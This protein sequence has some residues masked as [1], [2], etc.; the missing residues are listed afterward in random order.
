MSGRKPALL[1]T[2][3]TLLLIKGQCVLTLSSLQ[4]LT[5]LSIYELDVFIDGYS[6]EFTNDSMPPIGFFDQRSAVSHKLSQVYKQ[7][8]L[9]GGRFYRKNKQLRYNGFGFPKVT[10][11]DHM[12]QTLLELK[13]PIASLQSL[14]FTCAPKL[15]SHFLKQTQGRSALWISPFLDAGLRLVFYHQNELKFIRYIPYTLNDPAVDND[16]AYTLA[17]VQNEYTCNLKELKILITSLDEKETQPLMHLSSPTAIFKWGNTELQDLQK[18]PRT[19]SSDL[20]EPWLISYGQKNKPKIG[21]VIQS[22]LKPIVKRTLWLKS[23][24]FLLQS[25]CLIVCLLAATKIYQFKSINHQL[26]LA[27]KAMLIEKEKVDKL[28][29]HL[30]LPPDLNNHKFYSFLSQKKQLQNSQD[31]VVFLSSL[32]EFLKPHLLVQELLWRGTP[33]SELKLSLR[34]LRPQ[35]KDKESILTQFK[36]QLTEFIKHK[37]GT[38]LT[39]TQQAMHTLELSWL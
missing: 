37:G 3:K 34:V 20:I 35:I 8:Q 32:A 21:I 10:K 36:S 26:D 13:L 5:K 9:F 16:L 1:I 15:L 23:S 22:P 25:I 12:L 14:V 30:Q 39:V 7:A 31:P 38:N 11:L 6:Q 17:H 27:Q 18:I 24:I 2:P 28:W 4:E 29:V 33:K 19:S